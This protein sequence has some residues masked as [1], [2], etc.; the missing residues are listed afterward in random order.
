MS[1]RHPYTP[2][3]ADVVLELLRAQRLSYRCHEQLGRWTARC[4][5]CG[6]LKLEVREHGHRGRVSVRC[7]F[8][9][10]SGAVL[11]RL[12]HPRS[13]YHCGAVHGQ[14]EELAR[15]ADEASDIARAS[16]ALVREQ[17]AVDDVAVAA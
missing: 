14:A 8:G 10:D 3:P 9:C 6:E 5:L 12:T 7:A 11:H 17:I 15:L 16:L 4:P 2:A 13:C 1:R